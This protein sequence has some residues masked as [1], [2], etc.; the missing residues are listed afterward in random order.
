MLVVD[1]D[2][3]RN[4]FHSSRKISKDF[5]EKSFGACMLVNRNLVVPDCCNQ[6]FKVNIY[7]QT[8]DFIKKIEP[9][10]SFSKLGL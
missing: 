8:G 7:S 4:L 5:S 2:R 1:A 10:E 3:D 6:I 9:K